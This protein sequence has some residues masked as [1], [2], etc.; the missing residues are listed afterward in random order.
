M[1]PFEHY[2]RPFAV[3]VCLV[4]AAFIVMSLYIGSLPIE[5]GT[6]PDNAYT[7]YCT[8]GGVIINEDE[9][10]YYTNAPCPQSDDI[11]ERKE[12]AID[13]FN[14]QTEKPPDWSDRQWEQYRW[15]TLILYEERMCYYAT[16]SYQNCTIDEMPEHFLGRAPIHR[17]NEYTSFEEYWNKRIEKAFKALGFHNS[18]KPPDLSQKNWDGHRWRIMAAWEWQ[19]C[20]KVKR[21]DECPLLPLPEHLRE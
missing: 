16:R 8:P 6:T 18:E 13:Y 1:T 7:G 21:Y 14:G 20:L 17:D 9:I 12:H 4:A 19:Q 10:I 15:R 5:A 2:S 3:P 11:E